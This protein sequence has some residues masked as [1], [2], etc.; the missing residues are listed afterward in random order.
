MKHGQGICCGFL[1]SLFH[2][3]FLGKPL[4]G[5]LFHHLRRMVESI[6]VS[7]SLAFRKGEDEG[8]CHFHLSNQREF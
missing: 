5:R 4:K 2:F 6:F 3:S 7:L 8:S 1:L